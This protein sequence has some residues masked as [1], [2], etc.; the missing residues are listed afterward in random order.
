MPDR[1]EERGIRE[2]LG[3]VDAG[4]AFS[5]RG[6]GLWG[7][8]GGDQDDGDG[9]NTATGVA[10]H[11]QPINTGE[12]EIGHHQIRPPTIDQRDCVRPGVGPKGLVACALEKPL[13]VRDEIRL[14]VDDQNGSRHSL[15]S[16]DEQ[17]QSWCQG[18]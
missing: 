17:E 4:P 8:V 2:W 15:P 1:V 10:R 12:P 9:R 5:G 7:I 16:T 18:K 3:Q 11:G 13:A 6:S 14:V